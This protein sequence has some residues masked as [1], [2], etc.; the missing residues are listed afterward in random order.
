MLCIEPG[1]YE[2]P[3]A[4]KERATTTYARVPSK[5]KFKRNT[6]QIWKVRVYWNRLLPYAYMESHAQFRIWICISMARKLHAPSPPS[7]A[8]VLLIEHIDTFESDQWEEF[9]EKALNNIWIPSHVCVES[10]Y[11]CVCSLM[12]PLHFPA[13][14][15]CL[16][17][18]TA[19]MSCWKVNSFDDVPCRKEIQDFVACAEKAVSHNIQLRNKLTPYQAGV[20]K[21]DPFWRPLPILSTHM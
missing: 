8:H 4:A 10:Y 19:V 6:F 13:V 11:I 2:P 20:P 16:S 7:A 15:P 5:Y 3:K 18:M 14:V 1:A 12:M 9:P 21:L 17:E